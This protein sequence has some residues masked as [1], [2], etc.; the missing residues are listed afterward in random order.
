MRSL[1][2]RMNLLRGAQAS[3]QPKPGIAASGRVPA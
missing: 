2:D 3:A 1:A